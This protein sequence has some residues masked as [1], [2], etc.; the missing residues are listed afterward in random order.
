VRR[1]RAALAR[2]DLARPA[3]RWCA[4]RGFGENEEPVEYCN[5]SAPT[6][7]ALPI[8]HRISACNAPK[9]VRKVK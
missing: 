3:S 2:R 8:A 7:R 6:R 4:H 5:G 9:K 1:R